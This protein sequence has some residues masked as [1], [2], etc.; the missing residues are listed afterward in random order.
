MPA[1]RPLEGRLRRRGDALCFRGWAEALEAPVIEGWK[2]LSDLTEVGEI[3][4]GY[5]DPW[6]V[7]DLGDHGA[8]G[9]DNA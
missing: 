5:G 6:A 9:I 4:L 1:P 2:L 3:E 8:P 7:G